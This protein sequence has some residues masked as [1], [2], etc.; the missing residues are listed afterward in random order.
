MHG[1]TQRVVV[2][3]RAPPEFRDAL[4][5]EF[6]VTRAPERG[7]YVFPT[8]VWQGLLS[9]YAELIKQ[10]DRKAPFRGSLVDENIFAIDM[11]DWGLEDIQSQYRGRQLKKQAAGVAESWRAS[12]ASE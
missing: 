4:G 1:L 10:P 9:R 2:T 6:V 5:K 7:I 11:K 12:R 3:D 8:P